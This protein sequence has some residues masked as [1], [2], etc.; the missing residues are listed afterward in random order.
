METMMKLTMCRFDPD[1]DFYV[2]AALKKKKRKQFDTNVINAD[3]E[4][5]GRKPDGYDIK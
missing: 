5:L 1:S 2:W 3:A 4:S